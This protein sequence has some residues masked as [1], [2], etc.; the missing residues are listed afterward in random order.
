MLK[1]DDIIELTI[2]KLLYSGTSLAHFE[3][4]AV[5]VDNAVP[6]DIVKAR[7]L[8]INKNFIRAKIL[9]IITPSPYRMKPFCPLF[10]A[11]GGCNLQN[12]E[13]DFLIEQKQDI[14]KEMFSTAAFEGFEDIEFKPFIK[15]AKTKEYR[16]KVQNRIGETK[17]SKRLLIGYYKENTHDITNIKFCPIQPKII[18]EITEFIRENWK[19]GAYIE[20]KDKGLLKHILMR[21]SSSDKKI[22][23]TL[24][25]NKD[26]E[27]FDKIKS[28]IKAFAD[29]LM[30]K[31]SV[32]SGVLVNFNP[33]RTNKI[34]GDITEVL[35]GADFVYQKLY[36]K[37]GIE[38]IYKVS[39]DSFF[40]INP[41]VA[42]ALF[43]AAKSMV[44][45]NSTILDAYGG[46]G[47]IGIFLKDR[48]KKITLVE[49]SKSAVS[50]AKTNFKLNNCENYE[51][52][53][54]DAKEIFKNFINPKSTNATKGKNSQIS[55]DYAILDPPRKGSDKEALEIIS[56]LAKSIIYISCNP[57]TL[58]RDAKI[59]YEL[60]FKMKSIQGADM[61][62][63]THH[64]ES[65]SCF[66][67]E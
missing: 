11:C 33:N 58:C 63:F 48:A 18:D 4:K 43:D 3:G 12:I 53:Q 56:K 16:C 55:F 50:D 37:D 20:K 41:P 2:E 21:Y 38:Y 24:V 10:N 14:L 49:E 66:E 13:Y 54:G 36:S 9:D 42:Q 65:I 64:I 6:K 25:L 27:W 52:F 5:F 17:V 22:I 19:L 40:Q 32:I 57:S 47:T 15:A 67:K 39:K 29:T 51:V 23:L 31:F 26:Y 30:A 1:Q 34:T 35:S 45:P 28:D 62:P 8:R 61:F 46:V 59:L 7:V 60:G 44:K